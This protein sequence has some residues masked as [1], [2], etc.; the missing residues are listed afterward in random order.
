MSS[1]LLL[2]GLVAVVVATAWAT[3]EV[4][5][6]RGVA[7]LAHSTAYRVEG[8]VAVLSADPAFARLWLLLDEDPVRHPLIVLLPGQEEARSLAEGGCRCGL[9]VEASAQAWRVRRVGDCA[10]GSS[11]GLLPPDRSLH[12]TWTVRPLYS[13]WGLAFAS[14][15]GGVELDRGGAW[16][17][18]VDGGL[19]VRTD[20]VTG[21]LGFVVAVAGVDG[22]WYSRPGRRGWHVGGRAGTLLLDATAPHLIGTVGFAVGEPWESA[23][24]LELGLGAAW[25]PTP[26]QL[27]PYV[28]AQ[29]RL[30]LLLWRR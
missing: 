29:V 24:D 17:V 1:H 28:T 23:I 2:L 13:A 16:T 18:G 30:L 7:V 4:A 9:W 19:M 22:R 20:P 27:V 26:S 3:E 5:T 15:G 12:P 25:T 10:P 14:L 11:E 8:P 21:R 6:V